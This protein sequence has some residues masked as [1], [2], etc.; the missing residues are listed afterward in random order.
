VSW[1]LP[2][3]ACRCCRC[4]CCCCCCCRADEG[5]PVERCAQGGWQLCAVPASLTVCASQPG[6]AAAAAADGCNRWARWTAAG[7]SSRPCRWRRR[8]W[9]R[10]CSRCVCV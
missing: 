6:T 1:L 5:V 3:E 10:A 7:Q 9:R 4:C 8:P 2:G